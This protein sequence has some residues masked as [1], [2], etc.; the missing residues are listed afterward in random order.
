MWVF[1]PRCDPIY[2]YTPWIGYYFLK[3][4]IALCSKCIFVAILYCK[5]VQIGDLLA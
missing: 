1:D 4:I 3:N 2:D 5:N